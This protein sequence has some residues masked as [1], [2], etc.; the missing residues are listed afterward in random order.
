MDQPA[1]RDFVRTLGVCLVAMQLPRPLTALAAARGTEPASLARAEWRCVEAIC[2]EII[3]T[4][5]DPGAAEAGCANFI[6]KALAAED[7]QALPLYREALAAI[8]ALCVD[9]HGHAF[10]DLDGA[11]RQ[12]VLTAMEQG[13][14]TGW[15]AQMARAQDFFATIRF[16]ALL[17][18]IA[19]PKYGGN[20]DY[21]GW[22]LMGVP[23]PLHMV[24][25]VTPEQMIGRQPVMP[26]WA[27]TA[28]D[29]HGGGHR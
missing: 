18:F 24:G 2:A 14:L 25:G 5:R 13:T 19:D 8:D 3:P 22:K 17:G 16:H 26:V 11:W 1:R 9:A 4:D 23:G 15:T 7:A 10:A 20:R 21:A 28:N 29:G 6:D 27:T 12:R